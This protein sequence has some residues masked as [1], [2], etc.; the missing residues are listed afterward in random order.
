MLSVSTYLVLAV[1]VGIGLFPGLYCTKCGCSDS[2]FLFIGV[3][4]LD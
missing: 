3:R 1:A 4:V 2:D